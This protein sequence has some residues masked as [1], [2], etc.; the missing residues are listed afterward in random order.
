M[1]KLD[2]TQPPICPPNEEFSSGGI[3]MRGCQTKESK[4]EQ[5]EYDQYLID[6]RM[7]LAQGSRP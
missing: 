7:A 6:Y 5:A 1:F 4:Q 3:F 2:I